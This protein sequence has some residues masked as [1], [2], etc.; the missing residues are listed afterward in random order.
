M[1]LRTE[2][3]PDIFFLKLTTEDSLEDA[4]IQLESMEFLEA[5][6]IVTLLWLT[7]GSID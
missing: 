7:Q 3:V 2:S 4:I 5:W 6:R 1:A